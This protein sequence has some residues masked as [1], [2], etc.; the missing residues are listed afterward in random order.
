M[1]KANW[2]GVAFFGLIDWL[3]SGYLSVGN[4]SKRSS[5]MRLGLPR[6]LGKV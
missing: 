3:E 4:F 1:K 5:M 2:L 6:C